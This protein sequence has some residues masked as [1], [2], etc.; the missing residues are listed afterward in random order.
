[1]SKMIDMT[2]KTIGR[3]TVIKRDKNNSQGK[4]RWLCQCECG[5]TIVV[6]GSSLRNGHTKSCGCYQR[7][8]T[9]EVCKINL[10]GQTIGNFTVL[11]YCQKNFEDTGRSKWK[12]RCN[13]C[14]NEEVYLNTD[15][16]KNQYSCGCSISSKGERKIETILLQNHIPYIKEKRFLD[17]IFSDTGHQARFD[18]FVDNSY[19]IEF[20]GRQHFIQGEGK[21]DNEEKFELTKKHDA[22]K[23]QYCLEHNI[24][25]IRI[26]FTA[27]DK[28]N[29]NMLKPETSEYLFKS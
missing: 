29:L 8:R 5:K 15:N 22:I 16:L 23:N 4:A 14:G 2:G 20:D 28:I 25:L 11:D 1:M 3:L 27:F 6:D 19:I 7:D 9:S 10:I 26:P 12:C 17:L 18:F 13:L 21:Y 24:P